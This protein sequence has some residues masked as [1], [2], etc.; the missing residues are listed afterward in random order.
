MSLQSHLTE[1]KRKHEALSIRIDEEQRH[2]GVDHM[3]IASLKKRKL[4]LKEEIVRL[5]SRPH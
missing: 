2:P 4:R 3:A 1:L 5:D